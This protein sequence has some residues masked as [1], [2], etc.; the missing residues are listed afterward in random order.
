M[1]TK[2]YVDRE[3]VTKEKWDK[4][5]VSRARKKDLRS[6]WWVG[7]WGLGVIGRGNFTAE[8]P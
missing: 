2:G 8:P 4:G 7:G 5:S 6:G 3:A 1:F